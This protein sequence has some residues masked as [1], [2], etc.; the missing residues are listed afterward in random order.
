MPNHISALYQPIIPNGPLGV[1]ITNKQFI[2]FLTKSIN[3]IYDIKSNENFP[4]PLPVSI[5]KKNFEKLEKF[6]YN[7][8][9]KLD[10][11]RFLMYFIKDKLNNNQCILINRALK[12]FTI[13]INCDETL[14]VGTLFDGELINIDNEWKFIIHDAL[15]LG[16]NKITKQSYSSR[17]IDTQSFIESFIYKEM[18][19]K[20]ESN[21]NSNSI[22]LQVK[23]FYKFSNIEMFINNIY[24]KGNNSD[25]IIFMPEKLPVIAGTQ[26]SMFKWKPSDKHTFD[27]MI[28]ENENNLIAKVYHL[29]KFEEFAKIHFETEE[30]KNFIE[31]TKQLDN[32]KDECIV[33]CSFNKE[34]QNFEPILVRTDK[35]HPN[36]LRTIERTLFNINENITLND[37]I[38]LY[39]NSE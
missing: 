23:D 29:N 30:G 34:K 4:A 25:G 39:K 12:F 28:C 27:F 26:Y 24:N 14:F 21:S 3:L 38:E 10:G 8:S 11:T 6:E 2:N 36:S 22:N 35:T 20:L 19:L 33:E 5:E 1:Q 17:M 13:N 16:G 7:I 32:Y 37:F 15:S 18:E 31:K 9:L